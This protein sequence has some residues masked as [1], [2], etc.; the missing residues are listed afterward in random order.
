[1]FRKEKET[2]DKKE[3]VSACTG[4]SAGSDDGV[5]KS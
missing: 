5:C 3:E 1:M 2:Y 4:L